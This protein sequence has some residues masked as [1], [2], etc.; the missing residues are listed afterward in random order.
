A[1]Q[2]YVVF[3]RAG[4]FSASLN[5]SSL[6]GSNGFAINGINNGDYSGRSVSSAGDIN[7]DGIDDLI[8][9]A[10]NANSSDGTFVG[11]SYVVFGRAG[12]FGSSLNLSSLSG[13]NGFAITGMPGEGSGRSVSS[14]G[15][16][17]GDGID[18]LIIGTTYGGQSYVVFGRAGGFG[19]SLNVSSLN[20]SNGFA[21]NDSLVTGPV[22]SAGDIN[23]DG[24]DDLIIG[25]PI[26][27][28]PGGTNDAGQSYVVFGRAGGFS[29]SLNVSSLN[30][31]NGFAINGINDMD[32]SGESVSSAGDINGDGTDDLIIGA[33]SASPSGREGAGQSYV[34]FGIPSTATPNITLSVS[35][36]SVN[37]NGSTNLVYTFRRVGNI[38]SALNNV[39]FNVSGTATFSSD[40]T[41]T[42]ARS[43]TA[44][45]GRVNFAA[46][47]AIARV[48]INPTG[49]TTIE[50]NETAILTLTTGRGYTVGSPNSATGTIINDDPAF[51]PAQFELSSLN[52]TNGFAINGIN[53]G[54][55]SGWS[56]S[57]AG[58]INGDNIDDLIIGAR[59]ADPSGRSDAG[60]SYVVF[61]R[62][63]GFGA[64]LELSS[65][66]GTNG[67][68][69][70][71]INSGDYSGWSVS[72]AG[73]INGD[74]I[75]DLIIGAPSADPNDNTDRAGQSYVVFGRV[76]GFGASLNLS[77]LNGS[78][79]FA[80]NGII[81]SDRSGYSVS[82][83]GDI[84]GDGIDD[85]IIGAPSAGQ[86][87]AGQSYVVFGRTGG[88]GASF[89]LSSLN[90]SNGFTING[91]NTA[92][93]SGISV[94]SGGDING[95]GI[96]DLIIGAPLANPGNANYAGQ[97]YV[98]FG[99]VGG[100]GSSL[101]LSSL[102]GSNGFALNGINS[103][104]WSGWSVSS[105]GD[106]NG[107]DIDDLII[108]ARFADPNNKLS[109]GQS[110][111]VFG[112]T[113][114]FGA[115]LDL[116]SLNGSNGFALNGINSNDVLGT[117]VS[118]AGDINGDDIDDLIIGAYGADPSGRNGAGQS[119]VVFGR[120]GGFGASLD[121]SSLNGNNGFALNG[122]N[123]GDRSGVSVSSAGDINNDGI[124]DL[125][126]GA[127]GADPSGRSFAGQSYVVFG[128]STTPSITLA[129]SPASVTENGSTN[130]VYTFTRTGSTSSALSNVNFSVTGTATFNNDYTQTGAS[131]YNA[132]T[133]R[134]NFAAGSA[135]ARV[136]INP[137]GDTTVEPNETVL[138]RV[139]TGTGYTAGS[140][141]AATGTITNDDTLT[142]GGLN[143]N[144]STRDGQE[145]LNLSLG[146]SKFVGVDTL[147]T[148]GFA[149]IVNL[150]TERSSPTFFELV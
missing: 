71:G 127:D 97:S 36:T 105:A 98:V 24:I 128:R 5:L 141:N 44:T 74:D 9:G 110:Y 40:Y 83:G 35:P 45:T 126:I 100:F 60:Q 62:T 117:S 28:S 103:G 32:Y 119:Y 88:F 129:V 85:L 19:S 3:G 56:V 22:S 30:G 10:I 64:S 70:N 113:G 8:I 46:G 121:L 49:D 136:T 66:N 109:A 57:S 101:N 11:Q 25:A 50:P 104:D 82:S 53:N 146:N 147:I 84:N 122:I 142:Q 37:E 6:S 55:R 51:F 112:R 87:S 75:D 14:A 78:N 79:G 102:N 133:G 54:D 96:D 77:S 33:P 65:L 149:S 26:A 67:F 61:G 17:N 18:D 106:I 130:L 94:S 58:D 63:G 89:E 115:S 95:D 92:D 123:S 81:F 21:I 43:F 120:T 20:G 47:S 138:L 125:I 2:S 90:G 39:N 111:V 7:G 59:S 15:D 29:A 131:S 124:D 76:G 69:L 12:G 150:N 1:G 68:A 139:S 116:S 52:G 118:S 13:S 48:T 132:T 144:E 135:T 145:I 80:L 4:G 41:Q 143:L 140:P 23:R 99:R 31:S 134:V 27:A 38:T 107:D 16:I 34:V 72:S 73:D 93:V 114:G 148:E 137:T 91:I 42:G 86:S 108:G